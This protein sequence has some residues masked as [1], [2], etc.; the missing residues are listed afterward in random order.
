MPSRISLPK[1]SLFSSSRHSSTP[2]N[3]GSKMPP[4]TP[5]STNT[6]RRASTTSPVSPPARLHLRNILPASPEEPPIMPL[7]PRTPRAWVWQCHQCHSVYRLGCTRRCLDCSH[8]YCVVNSKQSNGRGKKRRRQPAVLCGAEFDYIGWEQWGSWKRKV[9]G[10]E[11]M[12]RCDT[13]VRDCAFMAKQHNCWI[14]C[15]SPSECGHRRYELAAEMLRNR[16]FVPDEPEPEVEAGAQSPAIV[17]G[18][19]PKKLDDDISLTEVLVM[20]ETA[21]GEEEA[22][23]K[24][25][26][27]SS[28]LL[29]DDEEEEEEEDDEMDKKWEEEERWWNARSNVERDW[30]TSADEIDDDDDDVAG[31]AKILTVRN[32]TA[33]DMCDD[34]DSGSE[35]G[36]SGWSSVSSSL[37]DD[38]CLV[39]TGTA[40]KAL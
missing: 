31:G 26:L 33:N 6:S 19:A 37:T 7:P 24:S 2:S 20:S 4:P 11:S 32:L 38:S 12:G 22:P 3:A 8:T 36:E 13:P 9:L 30:A 27:Q 10:Y 16:M 40:I 39:E 14:D 29:D 18:A 1:L 28:F 23:Q 17:A 35:S 25:P 5:P 15:D 34:S 21:E